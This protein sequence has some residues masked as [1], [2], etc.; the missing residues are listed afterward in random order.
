MSAE[1]LLSDLGLN[2]Q[3]GFGPGRRAADLFVGEPSEL[4][5]EDLLLARGAEVVGASPLKSL[6]Q[7]HHTL[8]RLLAQGAGTNEASAVL[9][10]APSRISVLKSDPTFKELLQYYTD[11]EKE[12]YTVARA[13]MHERLAALGFDAMETLHERLEEAPETFDLKTLISVVELT[14]DR[15]GFGKTATVDHRHEHS[16]SAE[17][18]ERIKAASLGGGSQVSET[19]RQ[20]LVRYA[21]LGTASE[22]PEAEEGDWSE[23]GGPG[24]REEGEA[25]AGDEVG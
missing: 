21:S 12:Q 1:S 15:T 20:A 4:T 23:G 22:L 16:L 18:L 2:V 8:A 19:D 9:G 3:A 7:S 5:V 25:G 14:A 13:N 24:L 11:M 10:M 17:T 6:R